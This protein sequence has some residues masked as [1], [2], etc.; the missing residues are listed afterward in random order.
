[1][2]KKPKISAEDFE[3]W[4]GNA[5]T[6]VVMDWVGEASERIHQLW[7]AQL[8]S[9]TPGEPLLL[10]FLQVELKAKLE[11][12]EDLKN[13]QLS[14]IEEEDA[15]S[16]IGQIAAKAAAQAKSRAH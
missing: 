11:L 7:A 6:Q 8:S 9:A 1:M 2:P 3:S 5:I 12:I 13:I 16:R 14:D 15:D 4:R 10:A